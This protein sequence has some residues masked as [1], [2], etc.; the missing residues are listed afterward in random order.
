MGAELNEIG[1]RWRQAY[2]K[3]A[4]RL[5]WLK[6]H[7]EV[8]VLVGIFLSKRISVMTYEMF[9]LVMKKLLPDLE[10]CLIGPMYELFD[11]DNNGVIDFEQFVGGLSDCSREVLQVLTQLLQGGHFYEQLKDS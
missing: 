10:D 5:D 7:A 1:R 3:A 8:E 6:E 9:G 4:E 11:K 2:E